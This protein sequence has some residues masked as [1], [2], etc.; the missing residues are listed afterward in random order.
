[1]RVLTFAS[2]AASSGVIHGTDDEHASHQAGAW[3]VLGRMTWRLLSIVI[4][5]RL[6]RL[7]APSIFA[8][9]ARRQVVRFPAS[10]ENPATIV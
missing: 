10:N 8:L 4:S 7:I 6:R 5:I 1:V 9:C 2:T 3:S